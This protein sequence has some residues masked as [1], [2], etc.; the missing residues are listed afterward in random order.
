MTEE[1]FSDLALISM[2]YKERVPV[3]GICA[4]PSQKTASSIPYLMIV[5]HRSRNSCNRKLINKIYNFR[6]LL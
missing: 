2:H 4:V 3:Q 6:F 1:H 5:V